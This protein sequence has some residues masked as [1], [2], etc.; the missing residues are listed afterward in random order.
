MTF[1]TIVQE[2]GVE[3][4]SFTAVIL[5]FSKNIAKPKLWINTE[6]SR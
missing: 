3:L 5:T 2:F 1:P 4:Q 6:E